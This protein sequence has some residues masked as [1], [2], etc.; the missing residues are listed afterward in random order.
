MKESMHY[1]RMLS[2]LQIRIFNNPITCKEIEQ[3]MYE[4]NE[5]DR[6]VD[7]NSINSINVLKGNVV[8]IVSGFRTQVIF[9]TY[10]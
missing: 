10:L 4:I 3:R 8:S 5:H 1:L 9:T 7:E 6:F 2:I